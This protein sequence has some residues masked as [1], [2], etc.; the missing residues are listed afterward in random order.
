MTNNNNKT[1]YIAI[2][3]VVL[4]AAIPFVMAILMFLAGFL[5]YTANAN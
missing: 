2:G 5:F 4:I 3:F 1:I